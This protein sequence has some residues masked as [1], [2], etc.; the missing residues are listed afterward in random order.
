MDF[1]LADY[2]SVFVSDERFLVFAGASLVLAFV[3]ILF[4]KGEGRFT[5]LFLGSAAFLL[6]F[7][8]VILAPLSALQVVSDSGGVD[9]VKFNYNFGFLALGIGLFLK[10]RNL[11]VRARKAITVH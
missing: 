5:R 4:Q 10:F 7:S 3:L 2:L 6:F 9:P 1:S 11:P 8:F